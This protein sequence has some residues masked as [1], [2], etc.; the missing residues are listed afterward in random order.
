M[1]STT[2]ETKRKS[3]ILKNLGSKDFD[4]VSPDH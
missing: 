3:G 1:E 4:L 2:F